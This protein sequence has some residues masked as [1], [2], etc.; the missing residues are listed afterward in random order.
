VTIA[1]WARPAFRSTG[2]PAAVT[3]IVFADDD[4]LGAAPDL[5]IRG[6]VPAGAPVAALDLRGHHRSDSADWIE[7]WRTGAVRNIADRDLGDL[8]RLDRAACCYSVTVEVVDPADLAHL[9]LAWAVAASLARLGAF[10]VL[11]VHAVSWFHGPVVAALPADRPFAVQREV[12]LTAETTPSAGFGHPVHTRGMVKFG[13]PDLVAGVDADDIQHTARVLN[14]LAGML[15]EG[16][17][18]TPGQNLRFD[19]QRTLR[20]EPYAPGGPVPDV[21][22]NNEGLL[23]ADA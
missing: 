5:Q 18:L 14:H 20:V 6:S 7:G 15:A 19:G 13:R 23:L 22:L 21:S 12:S 17:V 3:L 16:H 1:P 10:A 8:T 2:R 11:D 4:V 9:Q